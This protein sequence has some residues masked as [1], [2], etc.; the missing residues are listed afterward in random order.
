MAE[1]SGHEERDLNLRAVALFAL[2]L[3]LFGLATHALLGRLFSAYDRREIGKGAPPRA[4]DDVGLP[5]QPRLEDRPGSTLEEVRI[6]EERELRTYAWVDRARGLVS[7]PIE[8][9]MELLL[10]RGLPVRRARE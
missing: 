10:Q 7:I 8:R 9:S 4:A 3:A 5:P 6:R 2:G 1:P